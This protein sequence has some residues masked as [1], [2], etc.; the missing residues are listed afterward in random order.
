MNRTVRYS[1]ALSRNE[2]I[3]A[4]VAAIGLPPGT[5]PENFTIKGEA[6]AEPQPILWMTVTE[7]GDRE[8][9]V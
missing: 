7:E 2:V 6:L 1:Y 4:I 8:L 3:A 5:V 9:G